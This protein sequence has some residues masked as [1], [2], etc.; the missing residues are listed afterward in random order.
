[1]PD[2]AVLD[3][4]AVLALLQNE[5]GGAKVGTLVYGALLSAVNLC[6]IYSKLIQRGVPGPLS[7]GRIVSL[8]C[9]VRPFTAEQ[10]RVAAELVQT[11]RPFGLSLGDRACLALAV[12]HKARVYTADRAWKNLSL[13]IEI[14]V[15]R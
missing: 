13:G 2:T 10:G 6:E 11:T 3:S 7:W 8:Q 12:E 1:L 14:E 9:D 4:S 15:I 5:A